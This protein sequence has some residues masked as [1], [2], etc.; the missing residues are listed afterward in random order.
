M[1]A[2]IPDYEVMAPSSLTEALSLLNDSSGK[3]KPFAG[4]TD[5]MVLLEAGKLPIGKYISLHGLVELKSQED[6]PENVT[7]GSFMTFSQ[8][9]GSKILQEEFPLLCLGAAEIGSLAIQNRATIGGNIVN[10]SPA[11]DSL[12]PLLV[13]E[14]EVELISMKG[15]RWIPYK[16]FHTGYKQMSM[17][18]YELL[19]RIRLPKKEKNL[20]QFYRKV[21]VRGAQAIS[22]VCMAATAQVS[23]SKTIE[24]FRLA[25]GSVAPIPLRCI[26][27][28]TVLKGKQVCNDLIQWAEKKLA[29]EISPIDDIRSTKEYRVKV[30]QNLLRTFMEQL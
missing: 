14:A 2:F 15:S 29:E 8:I 5:L 19:S 26:Q 6:H 10:A 12:P 17:Y 9:R 11:A 21:G 18:P 3:W 22:K 27:T 23:T 4:G 30:A 7:I 20:K 13:Y 28:E 1:K 24:S 16:D 25:F